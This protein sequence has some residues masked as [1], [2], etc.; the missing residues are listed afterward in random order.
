MK[1]VFVNGVMLDRCGV[2][3][4][5]LAQKFQVAGPFLGNP[6]GRPDLHFLNSREALGPASEEQRVAWDAQVTREVS[7][8]VEQVQRDLAIALPG[9]DFEDPGHMVEIRQQVLP[10]V[11]RVLDL[12]HHFR[13]FQASCPVSMV[14]SGSDYGSHS[15]AVVLAAKEL[16]IPTLNIEHGFFFTRFDWNL[17]DGPGVLPTLFASDFAN[18]DNDLEVEVFSREA[19]HFPQVKTQFLGLG[20]P[21]GDTSARDLDSRT[22]AAALGLAED[23]KHVLMLGTWIEAR[24]MNSVVQGQIDLIDTYEDLFRSLAPSDVRQNIDLVIKVHPADGHPEVFQ[25]VKAGLEKMAL[26]FGLPMPLILSDRLPEALSACDV[27]ITLGFSSVLYDIF[28]L[29]KPAVVMIPDFL[30][31]SRRENWQTELCVPLRAKVMTVVESGADAWVQVGAAFR[32]ENQQ[33]FHRAAQELKQKYHLEYRSVVQKSAAIITWM[34]EFL[35]R[36]E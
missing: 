13:R 22:S 7:T 31:P 23:K 34:E 25:G 6:P 10:R 11:E 5:L 36:S 1:T 27:A 21:L 20:T 35:S 15:R 9:E 4:Q 28:Q 12:D 19:A 29:G 8:L 16:G 33:A 24:A 30:V 3:L 18:L 14:V 2:F 17:I 26:S 32:P